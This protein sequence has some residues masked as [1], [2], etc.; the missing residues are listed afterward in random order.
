MTS[1]ELAQT[2]LDSIRTTPQPM[3]PMVTFLMKG[4]WGKRN[5]RRLTG[6]KS[7]LGEIVQ[8][9]LRGILVIFDAVEVLDFCKANGFKEKE[10]DR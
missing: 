10:I 7:P 3:K 6:A 1:T 4:R 2:A 9:N 8:E 5:H